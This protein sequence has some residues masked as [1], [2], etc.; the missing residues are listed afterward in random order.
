MMS[1]LRGDSL[2]QDFEIFQILY[3]SNKSD[4]WFSLLH[5]SPFSILSLNSIQSIT[6]VENLNRLLTFQTRTYP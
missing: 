2:C 3:S 6:M 4:R 5:K 1:R